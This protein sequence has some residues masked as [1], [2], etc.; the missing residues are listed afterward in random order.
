MRAARVGATWTGK[1]VLACFYGDASRRALW[2][3]SSLFCAQP[4]FAFDCCV[5]LGRVACA[6]R[7][8]AL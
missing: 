4:A 1:A 2:A 8:I 6:A 3:V 7:C 5:A